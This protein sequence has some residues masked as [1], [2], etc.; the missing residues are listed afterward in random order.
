MTDPFHPATA[1]QWQVEMGADEAI[2]HEPINWFTHQPKQA[3]TAQA[4]ASPTAGKARPAAPAPSAAAAPTAGAQSSHDLVASA[5]E[6]AAAA[7]DLQALEQ[8]IAGFDQCPLAA[9]AKNLVFSDGNPEARIMLVGEA[10]GRDED[11]AGKPFVGR[12]GQLLDRML[13]AINLDRTNVY[14]GNCIQWRPP[15]NRKPTDAEKAICLPFVRRQIDLH[16]PDIIVFVGATSAQTL[17]DVTTGITRLRGK[18]VQYET[19]SGKKV[20][21][22]P[23]FH[24]AFLLRQP[25][26]KREAWADMQALA[27]KRSELGL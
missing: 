24:P 1:L 25:A 12:S 2:G 10:P 4:K 21:A 26:R 20:P 6:I 3:P 15:G 7:N 19:L 13:A 27:A 11:L 23:V 22:L 17:L 18:W 5:S 9:T 14:I 16:A 8:A